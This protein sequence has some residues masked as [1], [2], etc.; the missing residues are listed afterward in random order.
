MKRIWPYGSGGNPGRSRSQESACELGSQEWRLDGLSAWWVHLPHIPAPG[1]VCFGGCH[2]SP[3]RFCL[4]EHMKMKNTNTNMR[5]LLCWRWQSGVLEKSDI[6]K[7][8]THIKLKPLILTSDYYCKSWVIMSLWVHRS[9]WNL[10]V[11]EYA[12]LINIGYYC[13]ERYLMQSYNVW[14]I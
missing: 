12:W 6:V 13:C 11:T 5:R 3:A 10:K 4:D 1:R 14:V 7:I 9:M 8:G 2:L